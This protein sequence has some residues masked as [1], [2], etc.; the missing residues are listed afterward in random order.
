VNFQNRLLYQL[1]L[2]FMLLWKMPMRDQSVTSCSSHTP[3]SIQALL[4]AAGASKR[5]ND[6]KQLALIAQTPMLVHVLNVLQLATFDNIKV[7]LGANALAVRQV[8]PDE[9]QILIAK[10]WQYGMGMSIAA[11]VNELC[12]KTTH[13]FIGLA[14]QVDITTAQ[15]NVMISVSKQHPDNIVA[16][17]YNGKLAAPAIFPRHYF[18]ALALLK[19]DKGARDILRSNQQQVI[20]IDMPE[21]AIDIDTKNDLLRYKLTRK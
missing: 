3:Y 9:T 20:R 2:K 10:H 18:S 1:F 8:L 21:A 12:S 13:V 15:Y 6:T 16:A 7:I 19:N 14:D 11:G 5:F 4:L 17:L